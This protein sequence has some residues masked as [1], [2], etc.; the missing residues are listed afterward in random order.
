MT[1]FFVFCFVLFLEELYSKRQTN[2]HK[3]K[4]HKLNFI[5]IKNSHVHN[6]LNILCMCVCTQSYAQVKNTLLVL[7]GRISLFAPD[8]TVT[9]FPSR[10]IHLACIVR[11]R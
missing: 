6:A 10:G 11:H 2:K 8:E 4:T 5:Y 9:C 3:T 1:V 7:W